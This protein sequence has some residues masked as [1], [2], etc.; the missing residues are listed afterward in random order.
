MIPVMD[1]SITPRTNRDGSKTYYSLE[2]GKHAGQRQ[3]T[4]IYTYAKP[5]DQ[6]Q[7][8]H[9]KEAI[10]ILNT[11]RS[12]MVLDLQ[13][14][15]NGH[16]PQHKIKKNFLEFY[17][18]FVKK[19][20]RDGNRS[21]ACSFSCFKQ[22]IEKEFGNFITPVDITEN[23]CERFRDHLLDTLNG[24]TPADYFMRFKRVMKAAKKQGYFRENPAEDVK[25]KAH[26]SGI[27]EVL[28]IKEY[29]IL[30]NSHC[31]NYEV[32]KA[33]VV[34]MYTGFRWCDVS[35]LK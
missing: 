21:L 10:Q 19:N 12:Q 20:S 29:T 33:A 26:P 30:I 34:S 17:D 9:N 23:L 14:V 25:A 13:A 32:K 6:V 31:S 7:R 3:A 35:V 11:K 22:F 18:D 28:S 1:V 24:E 27:K 16:L 4:G 15:A 2:W 8:N 5:K